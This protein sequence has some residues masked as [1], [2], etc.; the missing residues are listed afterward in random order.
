MLQL[1]NGFPYCRENIINVELIR[2][3][4]ACDK[5]ENYFV[6]KGCRLYCGISNLTK[7]SI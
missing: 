5:G 4:T 2:G 6:K 3:E 1:R 7:R